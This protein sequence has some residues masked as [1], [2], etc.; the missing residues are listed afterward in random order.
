[1]IQKK[2]IKQKKGSNP[3]YIVREIDED[4]DAYIETRNCEL[5]R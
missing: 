5:V 2:K 4:I 1:V 3:V